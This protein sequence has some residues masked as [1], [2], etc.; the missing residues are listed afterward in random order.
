MQRIKHV[1]LAVLLLAG[2]AACGSGETQSPASQTAEDASSQAE[3]VHVR[4]DEYGFTVEQDT[5]VAGRPYRFEL[6]NEGEIP[7]EWVI[8]PRGAETE[9]AALMEVT[10]GELTPGAT[11]ETLYTFRRPGSY[12]F[13]C[14]V[15]GAPG[16]DAATH[17][18]AGMIEPFEVVSS[19]SE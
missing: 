19:R 12:D 14:Y 13:A 3:T 15:P 5:F 16:T 7:H 18:E 8:V 17:Y 1:L 2:L 11:V 4:L 10:E 6:V 9:E